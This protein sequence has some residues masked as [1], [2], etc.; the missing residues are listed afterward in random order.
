MLNIGPQEMLVILLV[1]LIV[2]GPQRLPELGRTVGGWLRTLRRAQDEVRRV[3]TE[4]LEEPRT[5]APTPDLAA[6]PD[7]GGAEGTAVPPNPVRSLADAARELGETRREI[8][9]TFR[10]DRDLRP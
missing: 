6:S 3:V 2:V 10:I 5:S 1:A 7:A 8:E 4:T 9:R